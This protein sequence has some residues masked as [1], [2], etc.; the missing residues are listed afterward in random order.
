MPDPSLSVECPEE[1]PTAF[2]HGASCCDTY[3]R[4]GDCPDGGGALGV[5]DPEECCAGDAVSK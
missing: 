1:S 2:L 5:H 4:D 3:L